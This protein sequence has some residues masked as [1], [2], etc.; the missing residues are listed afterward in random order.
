MFQG[1]RRKSSWIKRGSRK[2]WINVRRQAHGVSN[3]NLPDALFNSKLPKDAV[4]EIEEFIKATLK[5][6]GVE[7]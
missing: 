5:R 3:S 6:Y 2:Y 1:L 7:G 4:F